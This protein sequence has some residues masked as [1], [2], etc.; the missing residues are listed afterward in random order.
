MLETVWSISK[1]CREKECSNTHQYCEEFTLK[2]KWLKAMSAIIRVADLHDTEQVQAIYGPYCYTPT[3]FELEPPGVAEMRK[4]ISTVLDNHVWLV[5][6]SGGEILGYAY[7]GPHRERPAYRWSVD[8]SV[9]VHALRQRL[10]I[11]RA[12]YTSLFAVLR[13]QGYTNA[14]AGVTV[15]NPAS[16]GLHEAM[17]FELVGV[18]RQVGYKCGAWHDV[19]WY[20]LVL[21]HVQAQP[22]ALKSLGEVQQGVDWA[23]ALH[24]GLSRL[25]RR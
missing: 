11:G 7:A 18:Y 4:R 24:A 8:V 13:L 5:C 9:Y 6:E 25:D 21:Q 17:G 2:G 12:L 3:S 23:G 20:Q 15:P 16:I 10:G 1:A 19:A 14:F 22:P